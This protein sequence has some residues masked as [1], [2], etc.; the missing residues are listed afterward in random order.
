M[1]FFGL[2]QKNKFRI[3]AERIYL[4]PLCKKD[5]L[6]IRKWFTDNELVSHA[7]GLITEDYI[8]EKIAKEYL[9][10]MYKIADEILGIWTKE[11]DKLI[12][13]VN[14]AVHSKFHDTGRIGIIIGEEQF[15]SKGY[16]TEAM[17]VVLYYIFEKRGL[18]VIGL[19]TANF[20]V[21]AQNCFKRCGFKKVGD[22]TEINF[23]DGELIHKHEMVLHK[24]D[25]LKNI[26]KFMP[27]LPEF[28][29]NFPE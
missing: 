26:S 19:D 5:F 7:F 22:I 28:E 12:G 11:E 27:K 17:L 18:E 6:I 10:D 20:N 13:F 14:Y 2:F 29:G 4:K 15:R 16:G 3:I 8:L 23:L 25:F 24:K 9:K 1:N 21:R